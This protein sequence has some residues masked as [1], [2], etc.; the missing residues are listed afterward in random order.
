MWMAVVEA[1]KKYGYEV[2]EDRDGTIYVQKQKTT[3]DSKEVSMPELR[4]DGRDDS[5]GAQ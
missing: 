5:C 1:Y 3:G 4:S 2:T